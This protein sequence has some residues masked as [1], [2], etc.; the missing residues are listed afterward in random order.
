LLSSKFPD[1]MIA[2]GKVDKHGFH[3]ENLLFATPPKL[4]SSTP[5]GIGL[6]P[7]QKI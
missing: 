1:E 6:S 7:I 5:N 3:Q 4:A 2:E